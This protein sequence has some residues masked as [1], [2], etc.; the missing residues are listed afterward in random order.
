[1]K[2]SICHKEIS[3]TQIEYG[4]AN[5]IKR[6]ENGNIIARAFHHDCVDALIEKMEL[7]EENKKLKASDAARYLGSIKSEKK[8]LA[9]RAKANLPPKEGKQK[10]GR[11]AKV[12]LKDKGAN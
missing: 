9:N 4:D 8:T 6:D 12:A 5:P 3:R 1:M 2:C 10:R 7:E 11:P